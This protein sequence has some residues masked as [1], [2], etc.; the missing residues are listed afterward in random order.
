[1][2][3]SHAKGIATELKYN[4]NADFEVIRIAKPGST[5][6]NIAKSTCSD[7]KTLKK[8]DVCVIWGGTNDIGKNET[9]A[10]VRAM[11]DLVKS[12][13]HTNVIVINVPNRHDLSPSSCINSEVQAGIQQ[14]NRKSV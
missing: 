6:V 2:G 1:L 4:L 7:I 14:K 10:G 9:L 5:L 12:R 3:D 11:Y 13:K 8:T